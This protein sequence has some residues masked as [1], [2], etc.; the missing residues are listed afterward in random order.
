MYINPD[1]LYEWLLLES[2]YPLFERNFPSIER[3][4]PRPGQGHRNVNL[5][6]NLRKDKLELKRVRTTQYI[7][8]AEFRD[9]TKIL[10]N[11]LKCLENFVDKGLADS[12]A[13]DLRLLQATMPQ[14]ATLIAA[15]DPGIESENGMHLED[16][17]V[18]KKLPP[19][20]AT[21]VGN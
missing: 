2:V 8:S 17:D 19:E 16:G 18:A 5:H 3:V 6:F 7:T 12:I 11:I 15:L 21:S 13:T 14:R 9:F 1:A 20:Y 10:K 4:P